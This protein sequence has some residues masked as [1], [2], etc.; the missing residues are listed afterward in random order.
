MIFDQWYYELNVKFNPFQTTDNAKVG[1]IFTI[2]YMYLEI[3]LN[4]K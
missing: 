1:K 3:R 2:F 4:M